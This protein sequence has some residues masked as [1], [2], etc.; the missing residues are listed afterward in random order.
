[1]R[2]DITLSVVSLAKKLPLHAQGDSLSYWF[3]GNF[4]GFVCFELLAERIFFCAY[5]SA[6]SNHFELGCPSKAINAIVLQNV[7][8]FTLMT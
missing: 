4:Y 2:C 7:S 1:M 5:S 8:F 3:Q 6:V